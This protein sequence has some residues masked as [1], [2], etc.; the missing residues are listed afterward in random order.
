MAALAA[1]LAV[2][3]AALAAV[4]DSGSSSGNSNSSN[5]WNSSGASATYALVTHPG[6]HASRDS[7]AGYCVRY[8]SFLLYSVTLCPCVLVSFASSCPAYYPHIKKSNKWGVFIFK[9]SCSLPL[10]L[11]PAKAYLELF[12]ISFRTPVHQL[13]SHSGQ[14]TPQRALE[15][16]GAGRRLPLRQRHHR[17]LLGRPERLRVLHSR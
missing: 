2:T 9:I 12:T 14:A 16:S 1:D 15:S 6:H 4:L 5:S 10:L 13:S 7:C 3:Q 17:R 11:I 8:I